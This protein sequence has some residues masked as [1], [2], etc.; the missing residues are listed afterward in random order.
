MAGPWIPL[1]WHGILSP[2]P[3]ARFTV[4]VSSAASQ[5]QALPASHLVGGVLY[6]SAGVIADAEHEH[7]ALSANPNSEVP[8]TLLKQIRGFPR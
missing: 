3:P 6:A 1:R 4:L 2:R 8:G 5:F 7:A